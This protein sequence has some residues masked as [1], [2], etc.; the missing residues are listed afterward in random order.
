MGGTSEKKDTGAGSYG[1][2]RGTD[3]SPA[4][5][6]SLVEQPNDPDHVSDR[7]MRD[8]LGGGNWVAECGRSSRRSR[9]WSSRSQRKCSSVRGTAR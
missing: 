4:S 6:S 8:Q 9:L 7:R 5:G 2:G 3:Y 1:G